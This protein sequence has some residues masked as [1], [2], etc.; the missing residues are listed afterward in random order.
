MTF[1]K[2]GRTITMRYDPFLDKGKMTM[3]ATKRFFAL[4]IA[5]VLLLSMVPMSFA[6][7]DD[8]DDA[9]YVLNYGV[10][11]DGYDGPDKLYFSPYLVNYIYD[12]TPY[13]FHQSYIFALYNT[14]TGKVVPTYCTD[15]LV[16]ANTGSTYRRLNLEDSN[17]AAGSAGRLRAIVKNGFYVTE[18]DGETAE[19]HASRV[20][21]DVQSLGNA[22]GIPDLTLGEAVSATQLAIWQAAHGSQLEYS[23]YVSTVYTYKATSAYKYYDLCNVERTNG[24]YTLSG[25]KITAESKAYISERIKAACNYLL[26]LDPVASTN[27]AVSPSSFVSTSAP[28]VTPKEDGTC[29]ISVTATVSV[30]MEDGDYLNLTASLNG[31]TDTVALRDGRQDVTLTLTDVPVEDASA[32]VYLTI[33]GMQTASEVFMYDASGDRGESQTMIGMDDSAMPVYARVRAAKERVLNFYKTSK[34]AVGGG[35]YELRPLEGIS[36]DIYFLASME[37]YLSLDYILPEDPAEIDYSAMTPVHTVITDKEGR[38]SLNFTHYGLEDGAYLIVER[39]HPAIEAPVKPF[40]VVIPGHNEYGE[41]IYEFT[42]EPKNDIKGGVKIE[43]DVTSLGNNDSTVDAGSD[44]TWIISTNIPEDIAGG[45]SYLISDT[46]D[47]RLDYVGDL[48]V[49][50][51]SLDGQTVLATLT[52]DTDYVLTVDDED[53]LSEGNPSDSFTVSLTHAGMSKVSTV[54][55]TNVY[56]DYMIRVY[57]NARINA[58]AQVAESIPN[59]ALI[60][61]TN[62]VNFEFYGESDEPIV[63]TGGATLKKVDAFNHNKLLEGAEFEVYRNASEAEVAAGVDLIYFDGIAAPMVRVS[64]YDN[65]ELDGEKTTVATSDKDGM[66]G[67]Y[68]LAYGTYYILETKAPAGYNPMEEPK[69][70]TIDANSHKA[71]NAVVVENTGGSILPSTG[72]VGTTLFTVIG[73]AL[74]AAAVLLLVVRKRLAGY[75]DA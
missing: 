49:T 65:A 28:T 33:E 15:I 1:W 57:F 32:D 36:F 72:G 2:N 24:H 73:F 66:V 61:Y 16:G 9:V 41:Y 13:S 6:A 22:C 69:V 10:A 14:V 68:G 42:A 48:R 45:K 44:H 34:V 53:S 58:N 67:I 47:N 12:D 75:A 71:E 30:S 7:E 51:E 31:V 5:V 37:D 35:N 17:F 11:D 18:R 38:T 52:P 46:L 43:K 4:V 29:D 39:R 20:T 27:A 19:E 50:V 55:G 63:Y 60:S 21:E 74:M 23:D 26:S 54:L 3:K 8:E 40:Y 56:S 64:F 59:Q 25:G 62:S 70:I